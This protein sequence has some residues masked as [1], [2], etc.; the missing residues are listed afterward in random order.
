MSIRKKILFAFIL[1]SLMDLSGGA[2]VAWKITRIEPWVRT[3]D[4]VTHHGFRA[5]ESQPEQYGPFRWMMYI[6]SLGGKDASCREVAK[7]GDRPRVAVFGDSFAE[8]WGLPYEQG[9]PAHLQEHFR[10]KGIEVLGFGVASYSPSL[11]EKWMRKL[12]LEG[13]RWNMAVVLI[14]AGDAWEETHD[15]RDFIEGRQKMRPSNKPQFLRLKWY[16]YSLTVQTVTA[17]HRFLYPKKRTLSDW[18]MAQ[19]GN[20]WKLQWLQK[21]EAKTWLRDGSVQEG[22]AVER[23]LQMGKEY[24]FPV[25][26]VV[27]P[28]PVMMANSWL[29]N[30]HT[31][32][33]R[34]FASKN[35]V[36]LADLSSEFVEKGAKPEETYKKYFIPGDFH[37]ND[38]GNRLVAKA[39]LPR[40]EE[41][42]T[43]TSGR[44]VSK[45]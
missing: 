10:T 29:D 4:P 31:R 30:E 40:I 25:L 43:S 16:E 3:K 42:M 39:L 13:V 37:W 44:E 1:W 12:L 19:E 26:L 9:L 23:I 28:Y 32:F 22:Q 33:W 2:V 45:Q 35:G 20:S 34:E 21:P 17:L 5:L 14:D 24:N 18:E 27:Y 11:T 36:A 41:I 6:N 7:V 15:Y 38:G 8:G